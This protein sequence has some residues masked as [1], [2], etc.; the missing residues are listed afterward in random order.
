MSSGSGSSAGPGR[1]KTWDRLD[2]RARP[3]VLA[4]RTTVDVH[5]QDGRQARGAPAAAHGP[6]EH[7]DDP[8][9]WPD[10][11]VEEKP[12]V[13]DLDE[14]GAA[15]TLTLSLN[16]PTL[17]A[18]IQPGLHGAACGDEAPHCCDSP[19]LPLSYGRAAQ[20]GSGGG[21]ARPAVLACSLPATWV[22]LVRGRRR[23]A[24]AA[25]HGRR[26]ARQRGRAHGGRGL[27]GAGGGRLAA[28]A[29]ARR[30]RRDRQRLL[31]R[32]ELSCFV[33][34]GCS[35]CRLIAPSTAKQIGVCSGQGAT[36]R[37]V[38]S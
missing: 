21:Q 25:A 36:M 6:C 10:D 1:R 12:A 18:Y 38:V 32:G 33:H 13:D 15:Q 27:A 14:D 34:P 8:D 31:D 20:R 30:G 11:F 2:R 19:G 23:A 5:W 26:A 3:Q 35:L 7:L 16:P 9:F 24:A 29:G 37:S 22:A 4:T 17:R 28:A